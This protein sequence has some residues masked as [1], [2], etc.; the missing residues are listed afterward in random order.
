MDDEKAQEMKQIY[1]F[2][3]PAE[4]KEWIQSWHL[5]ARIP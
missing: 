5:K 4:M 1:I 2:F 3:L